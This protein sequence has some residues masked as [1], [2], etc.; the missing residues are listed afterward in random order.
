MA[1]YRLYCLDEAGKFTNAHEIEAASDTDAIA[2][3]RKMK[4]DVVCEL[5]ERGRMVAMLEP[6]LG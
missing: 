3:A 4:L 2:Q 1:Q 5:W 6:Q